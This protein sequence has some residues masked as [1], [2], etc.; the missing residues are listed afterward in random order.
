MDDDN[1]K[2]EKWL[3]FWL[4]LALSR[5]VLFFCADYWQTGHV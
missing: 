1:T 5:R 3:F 4:D 2:P